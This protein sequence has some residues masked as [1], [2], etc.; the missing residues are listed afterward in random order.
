MA[1]HFYK[2]KTCNHKLPIE[3]IG[4]RNIERCQR[5]CS[6]C[7]KNTLGDE[8]HYVVECHAFSL[9]RNKLIKEKYLSSR[10][11]YKFGN[12]MNTTL[13]NLSIFVKN[14]LAQFI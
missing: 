3:T 10:N 9:V 14:I 13:K 5:I 7:N 11:T 2:I 8:Y 12:L 4:W 6:L 1:R